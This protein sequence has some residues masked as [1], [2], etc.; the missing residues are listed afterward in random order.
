[1]VEANAIPEI[2]FDG[3][4]V[5]SGEMF[6]HISR[7]SQPTLTLWN[8]SISF[9]KAAITALNNCERIRIEVNPNSRGILLIPVTTR[10]KDAVRWLTK[11]K[12]PQPR[13]IEC[14]A[15]SSQLYD[16]W[17]WEKN[18]VYRAIG[19]IVAADN[20]VMLLFDFREPESWPWKE[21]SKATSN[22]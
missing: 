5:V 22:E 7:T 1:M 12:N 9:S 21:K 13:K 20:K 2:S 14:R 3:F 4:Q 11:V 8:N 19:R 10:D 15:F 6:R 17:G 16:M 18:H